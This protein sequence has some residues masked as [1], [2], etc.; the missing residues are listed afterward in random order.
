MRKSSLFFLFFFIFQAYGQDTLSFKQY[1]DNISEY[2]PLIKT[3]N[4]KTEIVRQQLRSAKGAF[5]PK[6]SGDWN[7]KDYKDKDYFDIRGAKLK[8]PT[9]LG[10]DLVGKYERNTGL[11]L[12]QE[13]TVPDNG[14]LGVGVEVPPIRGM[15]TDEN[16]HALRAYKIK[17]DWQVVLN[18]S[19]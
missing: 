7:L 18:D 12:N 16:R 3:V 13:R 14:L 6:I 9:T 8:V 11:F 15:F 10:L 4:N 19:S 17:R 5:D 2:H 1:L